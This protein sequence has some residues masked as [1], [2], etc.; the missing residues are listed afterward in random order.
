V[1]A[2]L[3]KEDLESHVAKVAN[4][5][6]RNAPLTLASAKLIFGEL[7][8]AEQTRDRDA[9]EESIRACYTSEDYREGVRA[10]LEKRPAE[11]K[12]R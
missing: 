11:F 4:Q 10:F 3:P 2:V 1:N 5:I 12:G 8:R 7:S 9:I 6:A